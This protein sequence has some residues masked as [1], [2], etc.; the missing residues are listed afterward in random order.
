MA[1]DTEARPSHNKNRCADLYAG[2]RWQHLL[3]MNNCLKGKVG[4]KTLE[5]VCAAALAL[6]LSG[7]VTTE[8]ENANAGV[9]THTDVK[10]DAKP[11]AK[12]T[13]KPRTPIRTRFIDI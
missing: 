9:S 13:P 6:M 11:V 8:Q 7:C 5:F 2:S 12:V 3:P 4:M 10:T 1:L